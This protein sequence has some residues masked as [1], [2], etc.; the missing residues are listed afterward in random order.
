MKTNKKKKTLILRFSSLGD[1]TQTL[2]VAA[3]LAQSGHEIHWAVRID[4]APLIQNHP[5]VARV[6]KL[7]RRD[8]MKGLVQLFWHLRAE[9]FNYV[10]DVHNSLRSRLIFWGLFC[11]PTLRGFVQERFFLTRRM[12]RLKRFL[13]I[14]FKKN[15]FTGPRAA[16]LQLLAPLQSWGVPTELP[17]PPQFFID[18]TSKQVVAS[19]LEKYQIKD[20]VALCPSAAYP[21]KRWPLEHW[22][23]LIRL[24]PQTTFVLLGG[25]SDK[26]LSELVTIDPNRVFNFAGRLT[27]LESAALIEQS[28]VT[29]TND[30]G[31][32]HIAE[33]LG[34]PTLALMGPA[35]FGHPARETTQVFERNLA[36]RPCSKHGQGPCVNPNYQECLKSISPSVVQSSLETLMQASSKSPL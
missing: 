14:K 18:S 2:S 23:E 13:W 32:M 31:L 26:F 29:I 22:A 9:N 34:K 30:T 8:G 5:A 4:L 15:Y 33:Q 3:Q 27:L 21:L 7:E 35:P 28:L 10:Y 11:L 16:Q 17:E 6:W 1:V 19:E 24:K 12:S 25:P 36:C 20:F